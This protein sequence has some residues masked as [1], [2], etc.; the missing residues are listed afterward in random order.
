MTTRRRCRAAR[1]PEGSAGAFLAGES[2][3]VTGL[4]RHPVAERGW[5]KG[6]I[7]FFGYW[8]HGRAHG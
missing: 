1:L 3:L 4:R 8:K 2:S 7:T 6:D 5:A